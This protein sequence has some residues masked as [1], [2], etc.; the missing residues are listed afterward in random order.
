MRDTAEA[1][2]RDTDV[3]LDWVR[4]ALDDLRHDGLTTEQAF[5]QV[6]AT[7][8]AT[9]HALAH[10]WMVAIEQGIRALGRR[11]DHSRA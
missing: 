8:E 3:P 11:G 5:R 2:S 9:F 6:R 4:E 1:I 10:R 7:Y